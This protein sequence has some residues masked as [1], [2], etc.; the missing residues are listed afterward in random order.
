VLN[1]LPHLKLSGP[2]SG[3]R[4]SIQYGFPLRIESILLGLSPG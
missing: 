3:T 1:A 4:L 2:I